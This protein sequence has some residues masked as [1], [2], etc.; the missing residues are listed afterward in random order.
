[1]GSALL[2]VGSALLSVGSILLFME[3]PSLP[4]P[5]WGRQSAA[6]PY[7]YHHHT[8]INGKNELENPDWESCLLCQANDYSKNVSMFSVT[9]DRIPYSLL[10]TF[11][12]WPSTSC[13]ILE[14]SS[15]SLAK[16]NSSFLCFLCLCLPQKLTR[17]NYGCICTTASLARVKYGCLL[18]ATPHL[19]PR[20]RG[21]VR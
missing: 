17:G 18:N 15:V 8:I 9:F 14:L 13:C 11:T 7:R 4:P 12:N 5:S 21:H 3:L 19:P 16:S 10:P 1:M 20:L 6:H 2:S